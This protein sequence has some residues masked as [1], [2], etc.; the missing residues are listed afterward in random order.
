MVLA[1]QERLRLSLAV[2][3]TRCKE[4]MNMIATHAARGFRCKPV[5][6]LIAPL[7]SSQ[8]ERI[9]T[10]AL[11]SSGSYCLPRFGAALLLF[12]PLVSLTSFLSGASTVNRTQPAREDDS[13]TGCPASIAVYTCIICA[14]GRPHALRAYSP[15][16]C[17]PLLYPWQGFCRLRHTDRLV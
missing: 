12:T 17:V 10:L 15:L 9:V 14:R 6:I 11:L 13:S 5:T 7:I 2:L 8:R 3:N 1:A 16:G 4:K